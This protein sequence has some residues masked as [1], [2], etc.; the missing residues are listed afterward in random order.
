MEERDQPHIRREK[1]NNNKNGRKG[2]KDDFPSK[3]FALL[4]DSLP[5]THLDDIIQLLIEITTK[6]VSGEGD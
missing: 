3:K 5:D 4:Q 6:S 2:I 1:C